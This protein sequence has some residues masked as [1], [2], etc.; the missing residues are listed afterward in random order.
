VSNV[1]QVHGRPKPAADVSI[2]WL[3]ELAHYTLTTGSGCL[4]IGVHLSGRNRLISVLPLAYQPNAGHPGQIFHK[5]ILEPT[6]RSAL[7]AIAAQ[8]F[9]KPSN[10]VAFI[11]AYRLV[12]C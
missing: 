12:F 5:V 10:R 6:W 11:L 1:D 4:T 2:S 7:G 9:H 8:S 3:S